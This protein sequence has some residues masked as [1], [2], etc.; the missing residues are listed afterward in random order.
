MFIDGRTIPDGAIIETDLAIIGAGAAGISIARAL[1]D[2]G[3]DIALIESGGFEFDPATQDLAEGAS[4]GVPYPL[5]TSRLRY[6]GGSTNHWGGWCRPLNAP[7]FEK[8][9]W[10]PW[11]GWPISRADLDPFYVRAAV[12]CEL[13][14]SSFDDPAPWSS[15]SGNRPLPL[16]GGEVET[17]YFLFSP[18]TRFG[19][20]YRKDIETAPHVR[21]YLHSNVIDIATDDQ[22]AEVQSLAIRTLDGK[23]YEI[24]PKRCVLAT[25][26]IENARLLLASNQTIPAGLGNGHGVV[27]R[28]FMEHIHVPGQIAFVAL[29]DSQMFSPYYQDHERIGTGW[30]R[31]VFMMSDDYLR[32]KKRLGSNMAIY[33]DHA[34]TIDPAKA[35][36]DPGLAVEPAVAGMIRQTTSNAPAG[37]TPMIYG[38]SCATEQ[39]P[40]PASRITLS[41]ETD[42]LGMPR[43]ELHWTM[44]ALDRRS[45]AGNIRAVARAFGLWGEGRVRIVFDQGEDWAD[46]EVGWGNHH[47]GTTRMSDDPRFGVVDA[48]CRVHGVSNLYVAGSSVFTTGGAVNPTLT[49][50][51]LALRLAD[52]LKAGN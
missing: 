13:G 47:M 39:A 21:T 33:S 42:A 16:E 20:R 40:D 23:G 48:D 28:F 34:P 15:R 31:G 22:A 19:T 36:Q 50:V 45:L 25:G 8:R 49:R 46:E 30:V 2:T 4:T 41:R 51:A 9:D 11:S 12:V 18:P 43:A 52:H 5:D 32:R 38:I 29:S 17:R 10:V 24:R 6:F 27:G 1:A 26:G 44:S 14:A 3:I 37:A 35:A 7:D